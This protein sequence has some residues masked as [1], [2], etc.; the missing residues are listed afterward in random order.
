ME[1][2]QLFL[3]SVRGCWIG[4]YYSQVCFIWSAFFHPEM[5]HLILF[6]TVILHQR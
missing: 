1:S 2:H 5:Q 6:F 3:L 4:S